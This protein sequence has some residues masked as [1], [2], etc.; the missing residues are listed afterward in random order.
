MSKVIFLLVLS[1]LGYLWWR[2]QQIKDKAY[3]A[4]LT[5]CY[6]SDLELLDGTIALQKQ[7]LQKDKNGV[8][9]WF[10]DY[11][12]EF[13]S[14]REHRYKGYIKMAGFHVVDIHLEPFHIN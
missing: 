2:G 12:F 13:T 4:V 10:R 6:K 9:R 7:R 1:L 3:Q 11:Q 8:W 5:R 14:T